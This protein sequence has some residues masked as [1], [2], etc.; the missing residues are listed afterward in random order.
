MPRVLVGDFGGITRLGLREFLREEGVEI[1]AEL[2]AGDEILEQIA[3]MQPD[4]VILDMEG[5]GRELAAPIAAGFPNTK[6]IACSS[7]Y[8]VM[9]IFPRFHHGES[10]RLELSRDRLVEAVS[11]RD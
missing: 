11:G 6:V 10:Y 5:E 8:P 7:D 1:V 4:V 3:E 9:R 2:N